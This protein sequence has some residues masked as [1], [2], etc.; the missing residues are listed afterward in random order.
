KLVRHVFEPVVVLGDVDQAE[1]HAVKLRAAVEDTRLQPVDFFR[2]VHPTVLPTS[3]GAFGDVDHASLPAFEI[4]FAVVD[5]AP[6]DAGE[7]IVV[8]IDAP[9]KT[10]AF[11]GAPVDEAEGNA[12]LRVF[13]VDVERQTV[14]L[15]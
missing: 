10:F 4:L 5:D 6:L 1:L 3:K 11:A 7:R 14:N 13:A 15:G 2:P 12:V 9:G 8:V